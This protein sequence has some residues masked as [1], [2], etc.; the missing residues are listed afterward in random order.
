MLLGDKCHTLTR[1]LPD[2][3][4]NTA[5]LSPKDNVA[6]EEKNKN[7]AAVKFFGGQT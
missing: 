4:Q 2:R 6:V 7:P 1:G 3:N 5:L